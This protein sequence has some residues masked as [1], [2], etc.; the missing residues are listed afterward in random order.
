M[1]TKRFTVSLGLV[2]ALALLAFG[3]EPSQAAKPGGGRGNCSLTI[4]DTVVDAAVRSDGLG[5]YVDWGGLVVDCANAVR[6]VWGTPRTVIVDLTPLGGPGAMNVDGSLGVEV[7]G[8]GLRDGMAVGDSVQAEKVQFTFT[9]TSGGPQYRLQY[10]SRYLGQDADSATV[11]RTGELT[12]EVESTSG[13][14]ARLQVCSGKRCTLT[15]IGYGPAPFKLTVEA[16]Q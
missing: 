15:T 9:S 10:G 8:A 7:E 11:T 4:D 14:S 3:V 12:W 2:L 13:Q 6:F 16:Q 1:K 5:P